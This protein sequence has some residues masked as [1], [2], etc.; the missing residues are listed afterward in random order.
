MCPG[1]LLRLFTAF[2]SLQGC[3]LHTW[4]MSATAFLNGTA[5]FLP[6]LQLGLWMTHKNYSKQ[7]KRALKRLMGIYPLLYWKPFSFWGYMGHWNIWKCLWGDVRSQ[8]VSGFKC[9]SFVMPTFG[10]SLS[11]YI[12]LGIK[13]TFTLLVGWLQSSVS[14][15]V[16]TCYYWVYITAIII[17][18]DFKISYSYI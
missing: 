5:A 12:S 6:C 14:L 8:E 16:C 18:N 7:S 15:P 4:S 2:T 13:N 17:F 11:S 1:Q 10:Y 9:L 3:I